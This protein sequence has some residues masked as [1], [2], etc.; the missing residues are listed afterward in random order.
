VKKV[1][2]NVASRY[3]LMNDIMSG[4][5][6]RLWKKQFVS[7]IPRR[8]ATKLLDVAGGTGD[9]T[10]AYMENTRDL[11]S[12]ATIYDVNEAML[13]TGRTKAYDQNNFKNITWKCGPAEELP[14]KN[15]SFDAYTI[16]FGLRN[17]T[18]KEK[19]LKEAFRVLKPGGTFLCLEFSQVHK[20]SLQKLYDF[21]SMK[22]IPLMGK[23]VA[24]D[25]GS[26]K[27]LVESIRRFPNQD[28][29]KGMIET[30]GFSNVIYEN[31]N[32]GIVA[33]HQ[34]WKK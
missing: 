13:E 23:V 15:N 6:H 31:L 17:V 3:D 25:E 5:M 10:L 29:L 1:F 26:Y 19:A 22:V 21:Y 18:E 33:I 16:S 14:F 20:A 34:G 24:K 12:E 30:A 11:G 9:I 7:R 32:Q 8:P 2:N 4:G 27:Y 28:T